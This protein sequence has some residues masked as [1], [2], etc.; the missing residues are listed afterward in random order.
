V[1]LKEFAY[2]TEWLVEIL[3]NYKIFFAKYFLP[4]NFLLDF[5]SFEK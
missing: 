4:N 1:V 5:G 3:K 2:L